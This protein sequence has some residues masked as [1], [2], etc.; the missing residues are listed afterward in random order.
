MRCGAPSGAAAAA[1]GLGNLF[2]EEFVDGR[3][4][5]LSVLGRR[6]AEPEMLPPAEIRFVEFPAGKPRMVGYK[7]KWDESSPEFGRTPR[8]FEFLDGM[9]R[10]SRG[11]AAIAGRCWALFGLR[12]HA[13]VDFRV[14]GSGAPWVLEVN[15]NPCLSSDA[16]FA[17]AAA[18]AGLSMRDTVARIVADTLGK[19]SP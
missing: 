10:C 5:N 2:I 7:A 18:R 19:E 14:D 17:A 4:F 6:G 13:R 12:G 3:E 11:S 1:E 9:R 8:T 16:G 15:A